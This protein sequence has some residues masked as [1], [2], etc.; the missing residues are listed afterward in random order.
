MLK[1]KKIL[2]K[3]SGESLSNEKNILNEENINEVI[4][5]IKELVK[6]NV[7][8]A[9][10][11]GAGNIWRGSNNLLI[12]NKITSDYVGMMATFI[13]ALILQEKIKEEITNDCY[14]MSKIN[15]SLSKQYSQNKA[16]SYFNNKKIII[17]AGG[18]GNPLFTT[19][20]AASLFAIEIGAEAIFMSKNNI[21]G[22]YDCDPNKFKNAKFIKEITFDGAIQKKLRVMDLTAL[23]LLN[24]WQK[25]N[26]HVFSL[27]KDN[28]IKTI[29]GK[30][31]GT[32]L[33]K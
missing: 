6:L 26:M 5:T 13:N 20:T 28:F 8:I 31:V 27:K 4:K 25:I 9:I 11:V 3:L 10:V 1:Y 21:N 12:K 22:V 33:H 18:T 19:D 15:C 16:I 23:T 29:Q 14:V 7:S 2:I 17:F 32:F 24:D 30:N